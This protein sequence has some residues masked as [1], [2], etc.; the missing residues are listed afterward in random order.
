MDNLL[1]VD[2]ED[3]VGAA[4]DSVVAATANHPPGNNHDNDDATNIPVVLGGGGEED[5]GDGKDGIPE[6]EEE[7]KTHETLPVEAAAAVDV[8]SDRNTNDDDDHH[9]HTAAASADVEDTPPVVS[10]LPP[11]RPASQ[12]EEDEEVDEVKGAKEEESGEEEDETPGEEG[13]R[14]R[15]SG[16]DI[17]S[18]FPAPSGAGNDPDIGTSEG[19][20][21]GDGGTDP[22]DSEQEEEE[23]NNDDEEE[24]GEVGHRVDDLPPSNLPDED[25]EMEDAPDGEGELDRV[26]NEEEEDEEEDIPDEDA[27][28]SPPEGVSHENSPDVND[29]EQ[30]DEEEDPGDEDEDDEP[31]DYPEDEGGNQDDVPDAEQGLQE[32]DVEGADAEPQDDDRDPT[33]ADEDPDDV[34]DDD[35]MDETGEEEV[36]EGGDAVMDEEEAEEGEEPAAVEA[37]P[38]ASYSTRGRAVDAMDPLERLAREALGE[39][40]AAPKEKERESFL[41]DAITE[42]ERRTRTRYIPAVEG[43]HQLRKQEIKGDLA[44]ARNA[45]VAA[46]GSGPAKPK[47][48]RGN[49]MELDGDEATSVDEDRSDVHRLGSK[50]VDIGSTAIVVPSPAFVAPPVPSDSAKAASATPREVEAV[51]AFNPPRPPESVGPKKKHRML[52]W[53]R[54]PADI[55]VDLN[56]YRKT[57]HRTRDELRRAEEERERLEAVDNHLRRHFLLHL[58][59][60]TKEWTRLNK[61]LA[62]VQQECVNSADLLTS[63]TRSRGAGKNTYAMRDV[64]TVLR[65][66]GH[67]IDAKGLVVTSQESQN[68]RS[69]GLGG[70]NWHSF[71]DWDRG[72]EIAPTAIASCWILPGDLVTTPYG[73]GQV[74][75]FLGSEPVDASQEPHKELTFNRTTMATTGDPMDVEPSNTSPKS[76]DGKGD[77]PISATACF[78]STVLVAPRLAVRLP[79]GV[80]F[81]P[82]NVVTTTEDPSSFSDTRLTLR[83]KGILETAVKMGG[84]LDVAAMSEPDSVYHET[85]G[86][87]GDDEGAAKDDDLG[88]DLV[89][90]L[91]F[92]S[93]MLPT[94]NGRGAGLWNV[95]PE[96]LDEAID[97]QLLQGCAVLGSVSNDGVPV[98]IRKNEDDNQDEIGLRASVLQLRNE[99]YRQRRVRMLNERTLASTKERATRVETL[100]A[101]MRTDLKTLKRRLDEEVAVLG[102]GESEAEAI[103]TAYY[104]SLDSQHSTEGSP[105]K[106]SRSMSRLD[107]EDEDLGDEEGLQ[108]NATRTEVAAST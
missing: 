40:T 82:P 67:E 72:T 73:D 64:L 31:E 10:L 58:G 80:G 51:T 105:P 79:F 70:V 6:E 78:K 75:A 34:D 52:R 3:N 28:A 57:V 21:S 15:V 71:Q 69:S 39:S 45:V 16:Q 74:V 13:S 11:P 24:D 62:A 25:E 37:P 50:T 103:V 26:P 77:G 95:R 2:E 63:R 84:F 48:R 90:L 33:A 19:R 47:A 27:G 101:E 30:A 5:A 38:E 53:E 87:V 35:K 94:C 59:A 97:S 60:M 66:R 92:G 18:H 55:E 91:P 12:E 14:A 4:R 46:S 20:F 96:L 54:R 76:K 22:D 9:Y 68:P 98:V 106:R 32:G 29:D 1:G 42:E 41:S 49:S 86:L 8:P 100:V 108:G 36:V 102:I 93:R 81:F 88:E 43:M 17:G 56:N 85:H 107:T 65:S 99:L 104:Q 23:D 61:E 89:R 7:E 83:W 44:L